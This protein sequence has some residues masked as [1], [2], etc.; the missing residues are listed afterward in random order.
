MIVDL[1]ERV[2]DDGMDIGLMM[3]S[4]YREGQTQREAFD[5]ALI[6]AD[7]AETLGFDGIWLAE[8]H[9][10]PPGGAALIA[11]VGSA[12][13]L[14][15]TAIATRTSRIRIGTAV[16]LLPL[17]HPVRLAEE[18]A[19]L[20]H[21]SQGRLDLGIGRSSF[22]RAYEGYNVPYEESRPRFREY[23]DVMRLAWTQPRFSYTGTFYTCRDLEVIPKPFQHPHPPLHQAAATR[24]TFA[25]IGTMGLSLLVALIGT[26]MSELATV[27]AVY[28]AAWRAAG[29]PGQGEVRLR[30]PVYVAETLH[31]ALA[32][33]R[34]SVMP[35]YERL[36]QGYL[37]SAQRL[38]SV[39]RTARATQ[40]ASLTYEEVMQ[41]RVVFGTPRHVV[42]RLRTLQQALG[43]AGIIIEPNVGGAIPTELVARSMDLFAREVAPHLREDA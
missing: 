2:K 5:E 21:L 17:G 42:Q 1:P 40:L 43:L 33:P 11:S 6:T 7:L 28:Q 32:D 39:E 18:V 27:I 13:L 15:A 37:R 3:D 12:P 16:L 38:E 30:L 10:S 29:H 34:P 24:E 19:T 31:A 36:R 23:L 41:E 8:R 4:D 25:A 9:F 20:D 14:M 26:P 35:Y 22:P